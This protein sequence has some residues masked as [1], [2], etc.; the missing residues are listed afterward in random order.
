[1]IVGPYFN[2]QSIASDLK[3][4]YIINRKPYEIHINVIPEKD[5]SEEC[6]ASLFKIF[7][8]SLTAPDRLDLTKKWKNK[9]QKSEKLYMSFKT[10]FE[11][12]LERLKSFD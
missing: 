1:M 6:I 7:N 2:S 10:L 3:C 11:R 12:N 9:L 5:I 8:E 4:F